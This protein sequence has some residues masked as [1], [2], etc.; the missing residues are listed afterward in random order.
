MAYPAGK[1]T[2]SI[3]HLGATIEFSNT[4]VL[5]AYLPADLRCQPNFDQLR[6]TLS[7]AFGEAP[8]YADPTHLALW[9]EGHAAG[10]DHL[11]DRLGLDIDDLAALEA[12]EVTITINRKDKK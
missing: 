4:A 1:I 10:A 2:G 6:Y 7:E 9:A 12:G 11:A 3:K 5:A 8:Q